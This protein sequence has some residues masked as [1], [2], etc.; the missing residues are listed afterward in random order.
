ML[1]R[2]LIA[3][4]WDVERATVMLREHYR[5][6]ERKNLEAG[7]CLFVSRSGWHPGRARSISKACSPPTPKNSRN[8]GHLFN[9]FENCLGE[10]LA[11]LKAGG[12]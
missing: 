11:N 2:F 12:C 4:Q 6:L 9:A 1:V 3:R 8:L 10:F 5:F 7:P